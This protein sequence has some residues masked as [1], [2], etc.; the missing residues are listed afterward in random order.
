MAATVRSATEDSSA[1]IA[2]ATAG[3][4]V[5]PWGAT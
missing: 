5:S 1:R 3:M 4:N 2:S